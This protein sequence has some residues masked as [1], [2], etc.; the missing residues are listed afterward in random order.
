MITDFKHAFI[1]LI[2]LQFSQHCSKTCSHV[3]FRAGVPADKSRSTLDVKTRKASLFFRLT[4]RAT[5]NLPTSFL[6]CQAVQITPWYQRVVFT[7][8][9]R[10]PRHWPGLGAGLSDITTHLTGQCRI[11]SSTILLI[12]FCSYSRQKLHQSTRQKPYMVPPTA[13]IQ[14]MLKGKTFSRVVAAARTDSE[15]LQASSSCEF[16]FLHRAFPRPP[17]PPVSNLSLRAHLC[18]SDLPYFL[19]RTLCQYQTYL[20]PSPPVR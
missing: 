4:S 2:S 20:Y 11:Q 1:L 6:S 18:Q 5:A 9:G 8:D 10:Q 14:A 3:S 7:K 13:F 19:H 16:L 15:A 12:K 17:L